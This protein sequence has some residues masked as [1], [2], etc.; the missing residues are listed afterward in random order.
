MV[1]S[2]PTAVPLLRE[3]VETSP[4]SVGKRF[5]TTG[6]ATAPTPEGVAAAA[7]RI[8]VFRVDPA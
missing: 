5:V 7:D 8:A 3:L 4:A 2:A 6:L 1:G